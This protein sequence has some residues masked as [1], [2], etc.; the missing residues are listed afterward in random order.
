MGNEA[1]LNETIHTFYYIKANIKSKSWASD[2]KVLCSYMN[3]ITNGAGW[4]CL[5]YKDKFNILI[6]KPGTREISL[7]HYASY[8]SLFLLNLSLWTILVN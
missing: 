5:Y 6:N 4:Q 8:Q 2:E 7:R 3:N 1:K